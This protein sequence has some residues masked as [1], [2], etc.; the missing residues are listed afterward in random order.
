M[1]DTC[2]GIWLLR[3]IIFGVILTF[4]R[5]ADEM[6]SITGKLPRVDVFSVEG[7]VLL[8]H[9][10]PISSV[11]SSS[12]MMGSS[13]IFSV[14]EF[15]KLLLLLAGDIESNPGPEGECVVYYYYSPTS[16]V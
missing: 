9:N 3:F 8:L 7:C 2:R 15:F 12:T 16:I 6:K 14:T 11:G 4:L 5:Y 13:L 1:D 10:K